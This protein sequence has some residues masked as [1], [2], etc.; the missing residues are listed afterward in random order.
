MESKIRRDSLDAT[1]TVVARAICRIVERSIPTR[2]QVQGLSR[3]LLRRHA[4][5]R[6]KQVVSAE[7]VVEGYYRCLITDTLTSRHALIRAAIPSC[8][9]SS[10]C[11]VRRVCVVSGQHNHSAVQDGDW[12]EGWTFIQ[13]QN[14]EV[15]VQV[16]GD[17]ARSAQTCTSLRISRSSRWSSSPWAQ[18]A[19]ATFTVARHRFAA[20]P[21]ATQ[22]QSCPVFRSQ[23]ARARSGGS[24]A[25]PAH[26]R[27]ERQSGQPRWAGDFYYE[28][29]RL[30]RAGANRLPGE[31][32]RSHRRSVL[33][34]RKRFSTMVGGPSLSA[35]CRRTSARRTSQMS[36][37]DRLTWCFCV[38]TRRSFSWK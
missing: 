18:A 38:R 3:Q 13:G 25:Y 29:G 9:N 22:W 20:M 14:A 28:G 7:E 5:C 2:V 19:C 24:E 12:R 16:P 32:F 27:A 33:D 23:Q 8:I 35:R 31:R 11:A 30:T 37:N 17:G 10:H 4:V 36:W 15:N 26:R 1:P 6:L 21:S 34:Q